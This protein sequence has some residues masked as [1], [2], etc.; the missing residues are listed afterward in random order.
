L[1]IA[2]D[3][4]GAACTAA[5]VEGRVLSDVLLIVA[6]LAWLQRIFFLSMFLRFDQ[7]V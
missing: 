7:V 2:Y 6:G 4:Q 1:S 5:K 3:I